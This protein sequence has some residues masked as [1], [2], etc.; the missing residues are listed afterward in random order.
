MKRLIVSALIWVA[1]L[2][3]ATL[4]DGHLGP[5]IPK[6]LGDPHPEGTHFMRIIHMDLML[7]DRDETVHFGNRDIKYSLKECVACHVVAGPDELPASA[8]NE[9]HFAASVTK[10]YP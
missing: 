9:Q 1:L 2:G 6:A 7:H 8:S 5:T 10:S 3:G 4:A